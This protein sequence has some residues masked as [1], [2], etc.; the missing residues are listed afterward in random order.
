MIYSD[1]QI[2]EQLLLTNPSFRNSVRKNLFFVAIQCNLFLK[3]HESINR[4]K[5]KVFQF[6]IRVHNQLSFHRLKQPL[7]QQRMKILVIF[8]NLHNR[9]LR[10]VVTS[11]FL[12]EC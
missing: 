11:L 10:I 6:V 5:R 8:D 9:Y 12:F 1:E 7:E 4:A 2:L 3:N